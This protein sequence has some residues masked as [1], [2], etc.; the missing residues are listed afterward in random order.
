MHYGQICNQGL[1]CTLSGGDRTMA[2]FMAV[3]LDREGRMRF[4]YNDTTSQHHGAHVFEVRQTGGPSALGGR[5]ND[6]AVR[7]PVSDPTGDAQVPHYFPV[8]GAGPSLPRFDFTRLELS[9]PNRDTLR[10]RMTVAD[11]SSLAPPPGKI[12]AVWLTRF[13]ALSL[14]DGL[15][16]EGPEEA[17][18]IFYVGAESAA[19][20]PPR[21]FAGSGESAQEEVRGNG[22]MTTT[23][24]NCKVVQYPA[25]LPAEGR[26]DGNTITIDVRIQGGFG[27][28][29][30]IKAQTLSS[31]TA[32]SFGRN[33]DTNDLYTDIDATPAFDFELKR[34]K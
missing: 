11:L 33:D 30:P 7:S 31:V 19:G 16:P 29:R 27:A 9:Q 24:E 8:T 1:G 5:V 26:V 18:R 14:G 28:D 4:V 13:Q 2:D 3:T 10:V 32:L 34:A 6:R 12:S 21:F 15:P 22:C 20:G 25:E 17:F 23:P